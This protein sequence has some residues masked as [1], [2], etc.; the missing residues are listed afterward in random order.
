MVPERLRLVIDQTRSLADA[1]SSAG[2]RL[3]LVG[4]VVRDMFVSV[5]HL[6]GST[7]D[8]IDLTTDATPDQILSVVRPL[9]QELW[10][11]GKRFGTIGCTID[12]NRCEITTHRA[13]AYAPDSRKPEVEFSDKVEDDLSRRD[14]TVNAMALEIT[15]AEPQ[16][17]D[18][19]GGLADLAERRL[20]T[21]VEP[22]RSFSDD[23][24]RMMRAARFISRFDLEPDPALVAAVNEMAGRMEIVSAERVRD[25]LCKLMVVP[26]P[27]KG[28]WFLHD[29]GLS[30]TFLPELAGLRLE[31]DP[32]HRHK[33]VLTHSI[34]VVAKAPPRQR[35]RL[36]ALFHD[37]GKPRTRAI[38]D[39]GVSF[40][41]HEVV[42]AR[43]T[44]DRMK[45]L[46]FSNDMTAEVTELVYLHLRF[47]TFEMGW[48]DAAVRRFVR[49]AGP[50]LDDLIDL[51]RS[52]C[53]TRNKKKAERLERNLDVLAA[54][55]A[56]LQEKEE[57][58]SIRP[59]LDGAAVMAHL[60]IP[61]GR[62]V[63]DALAH[64]LELRLEHGPLEHDAA[65]AELDSWWAAREGGTIGIEQSAGN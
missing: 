35:V 25:E 34:A 50:L 20:R 45:A 23:P 28:L 59:D 10:E 65:L 16:L 61:P 62:V 54:R 30:D 63:G 39:N 21:P 40:H 7:H 24:L 37:V 60:G 2:F 8:D 22:E 55:I 27:S 52:D 4:G 12:G 56:E 14:F 57:L 44:R 42:G 11:Q 51:T 26:D 41:H 1:F 36:A 31:Q 15:A 29:T 19:F 53:T 5:E 38:G 48:T 33:D 43:M 6:T 18:P 64:L 9:A 47:H 46:K 3:Y 17:I 58:A 32:I 13:E 49:D